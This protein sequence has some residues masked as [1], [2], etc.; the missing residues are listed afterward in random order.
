MP[1]QYIFHRYGKKDMSMMNVKYA[2]EVDA[3]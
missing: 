3:V 2:C 1:K